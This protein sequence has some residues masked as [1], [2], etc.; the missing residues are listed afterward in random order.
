MKL[1]HYLYI[2]FLFFSFASCDSIGDAAVG[3]QLNAEVNGV[4]WEFADVEVNRS[5]DALVINAKG[6][7]ADEDGGE[8]VNLQ[9]KIVGYPQQGEIETPYEASFAPNTQEIA[10]LATLIPEDGAAVF[11]TKLNPN[12]TGTIVITE[13][14]DET[15]SGRFN[16][17]AAD[18][19][20]RTLE[21][22]N[23]QFEGI[24]Y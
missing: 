11:D 14:D 21:V 5:E 6:Y 2:Y 9:M 8:G 16:F 4:E 18:E 3:H 19:N 12:T 1:K 23:G 13:A 22:T 24:P 7:V 10:A 15:I 20:G 17:I